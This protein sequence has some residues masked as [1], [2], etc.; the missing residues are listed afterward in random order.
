MRASLALALVGGVSATSLFNGNIKKT[1]EDFVQKYGKRYTSAQEKLSRFA[2]FV[3][4]LADAERRNKEND[5]ARFGVTQFSDLSFEEYDRLNGFRITPE[6]A[7]E[8]SERRA[9]QGNDRKVHTARTLPTAFDWVSKGAVTEVKDQKVCGSCWA[10][11]T[12]ASIEGN[13]FVQNKELISLSEQELV[14][15]D[16]VDHGC[17]GGLPENAYQWMLNNKQ[18]LETEGD[19]SYHAKD[20]QCA[21]DQ[22]KERVFLENWQAISTDEDEIAAALMQY[23]PLAVGIHAGPPL[24]SYTGGIFQGSCA[25]RPNHAV[26]IVGFGEEDGV[27]FWNVKNSW[28]KSFGENGYFRILRGAGQCGINGHVT[29]AEVQV[30]QAIF[31]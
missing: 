22:S 31:V 24:Q 18:G 29:A 16:N 6:A 2:I 8:F 1:F 28:G 17:H 3:D 19:Y 25:G 14:S 12:V 13:N 11:G 9:R 27:K 5:G 15:C 20:E 21:V 4:N 7:R 23:G 30:K 10:F 26:T